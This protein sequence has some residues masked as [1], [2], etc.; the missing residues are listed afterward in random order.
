MIRHEGHVDKVIRVAG[1]YADLDECQVQ[2]GFDTYTAFYPYAE[3]LQLQDQDVVYV[4]R[5]D[6]VH[7]VETLVITEITLLNVVNTVERTDNV[8]LCPIND[9][10]GVCNFDYAGVAL[11]NFYPG[12]IVF[13]TGYKYNSSAKSKWV[14]LQCL[15]KHSKMC[16]IRIFNSTVDKV[17]AD[18]LYKDFINRY[19]KAD[20]RCTAYGL[21][22]AAVEIVPIDA[23]VSPS[24]AVA[25]AIVMEELKK[26]QDVQELSDKLDY[27]GK[28]ER[29][30][31]PE[32][33]WSIVK[34]AT[35]LNVINSFDNIVSGLDME[36]LRKAALLS[37]LKVLPTNHP[38]T[39]EVKTILMLRGVS[40]L[41]SNDDLL[42]LLGTNTKETELQA[43]YRIAV[44]TVNK[45]IDLRYM[46]VFQ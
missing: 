17:E 28:L 4:L 35:L 25:K 14:D 12:S 41:G 46:E 9:N 36:L 13:V 26:H 2:I 33:G 16:S 11:G 23:V 6:I 10:R 34:I 29:I 21:Q 3:L 8:K 1:I 42:I 27:F 32:P 20:I 22:T 19:V 24:I 31:N 15:D 43:A 45:L 5:K 37:E 30:V 44:D 18:N 7:G 39:D 38:Y 40:A